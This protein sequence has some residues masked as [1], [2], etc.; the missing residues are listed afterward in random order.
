MGQAQ[1]ETEY[2]QT[3]RE[4]WEEGQGRGPWLRQKRQGKWASH[5][6]TVKTTIQASSSAG[7][8]IK[9]FKSL[10]NSGMRLNKKDDKRWCAQGACSY[11][12]FFLNASVVF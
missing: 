2:K 11:K 9:I 7:L 6:S 8:V 4:N 10:C 12:Y 3:E 1:K 5:H